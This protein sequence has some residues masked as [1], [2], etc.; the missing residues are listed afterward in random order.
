LYSNIEGYEK[1][2]F[3]DKLVSQK[4][5]LKKSDNLVNDIKK[6]DSLAHDIKRLLDTQIQLTN[7]YNLSIQSDILLLDT[8]NKYFDESE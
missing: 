4:Q 7:D 3:I 5:N 6:E 2:I 1:E 8:Y